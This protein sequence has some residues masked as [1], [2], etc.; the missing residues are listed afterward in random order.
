MGGLLATRYSRIPAIAVV[1]HGIEGERR[2]WGASPYAVTRR[3]FM[4]HVR[5]VEEMGWATPTIGELSQNGTPP[6]AS[7]AL[8]FDDGYRDN[9]FAFEALASRNMRA[10]WYVVSGSVGG[11]ARWLAQDQH[12]EMMSKGELRELAA[13]GMQIGAHSVS[14]ARL[15]SL[16]PAELR[17]EI[18]D[19]RVQLQ[20]LV[21]IEI[22]SLAYPYGA[23]NEAVVE[24][25]ARCGIKTG[26]TTEPGFFRFSEDKLRIKR[27]TMYRGD[28]PKEFLR[29][30]VF[31]RNHVG[32]SGEARYYLG[33]LA[34]RLGS[35]LRRTG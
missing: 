32:F 27:I 15:V 11:R 6:S 22:D 16:P 23:Y 17:R 19:S 10:T 20:D 2:D 13:A 33:R 8:T 4:S 26:C 29:K 3:E 24:E 5:V 30:V 12:P 34:S 9:L 18:A 14:H 7:L 28:G 25:A 31:G 35:G 1:Y 21:G